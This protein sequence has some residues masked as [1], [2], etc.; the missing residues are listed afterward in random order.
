M[1]PLI[2][3]KLISILVSRETPPFHAPLETLCILLVPIVRLSSRF[4]MRIEVESFS[5]LMMITRSHLLV[6]ERPVLTMENLVNEQLH[7]RLRIEADLFSRLRM[8]IQRCLLAEEIFSMTLETLA[9]RSLRLPRRTE[10]IRLSAWTL[11]RLA[12]LL[13]HLRRQKDVIGTS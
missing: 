7:A 13:P 12:K 1:E 8:I 4:L 5:R 3:E 11:I 9:N 10:I 2:L 6:K